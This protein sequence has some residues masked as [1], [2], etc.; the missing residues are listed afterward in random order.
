MTHDLRLTL[1]A[2]AEGAR[3]AAVRIRDLVS[4]ATSADALACELAVAEAAA[5]AVRHADA[6]KAFTIVA[7]VCRSRFV[8]AVCHRGSPGAFPVPQMPPAEAES[9][10]GLALIAACMEHVRHVVDDGEH[11]VVMARR[12]APLSPLV[13]AAAHSLSEQDIRS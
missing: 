2:D 12:L 1:P 6:A 10:R 5:N 13:S 9:G 4:S 3:V 11:R 7:R 8:A